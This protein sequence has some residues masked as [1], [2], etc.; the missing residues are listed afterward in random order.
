MLVCEGHRWATRR[1]RSPWTASQT[2]GGFR[3]DLDRWT[4][5]WWWETCPEQK[6]SQPNGGVCTR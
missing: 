1:Q 2:A 4:A 6:D 3:V 5:K